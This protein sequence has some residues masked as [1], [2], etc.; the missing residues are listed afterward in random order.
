MQQQMVA[1]EKGGAVVGM[2]WMFL[3]SVLLFWLP[4]FGPLIAG[5]VGGKKAGGIGPALGAVFLPAL[6]LAALFFV[7]GTALTFMPVIGALIGAGSF[8]AAAGLV[9][10]P[11]LLGAVIGGALA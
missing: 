1:H 10:G 9:S 7:F 5:F 4:F 2:L 6:I 8:I 11:L 3:I